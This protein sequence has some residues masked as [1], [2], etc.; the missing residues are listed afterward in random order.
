M[1]GDWLLTPSLE[2]AATS[3]IRLA[4]HI[5]QVQEAKRG[6]AAD[7]LHTVDIGLDCGFKAVAGP[8]AAAIGSF[9]A[10][11]QAEAASA[12]GPKPR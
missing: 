8:G 4:E 2:G 3:G 6:G 1:C 5:K 10:A 12:G 9:S 11:P 7:G